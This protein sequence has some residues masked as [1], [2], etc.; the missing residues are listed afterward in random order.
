MV[1]SNAIEIVCGDLYSAKVNFAGDRPY[2]DPYMSVTVHLDPGVGPEQFSAT[3]ESLG[4]YYEIKFKESY[5]V[6]TI[7]CIIA[8]N[9]TVIS[10]TDQVSITP[11]ADFTFNFPI[12]DGVLEIPDWLTKHIIPTR[13]DYDIFVSV[14]T[15][16]SSTGHYTPVYRNVIE[17]LPRTNKIL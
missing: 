11:D 5:Q 3:I 12:N 13:T 6:H 2:S 4:S 15:G 7:T 1:R 16:D 9:G 8:K 10:G 14:P 17:F